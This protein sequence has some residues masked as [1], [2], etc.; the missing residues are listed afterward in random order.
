MT[1]GKASDADLGVTARIMSRMIGSSPPSKSSPAAVCR[2][3]LKPQAKP[4]N[5]VRAAYEQA[6]SPEGLSVPTHPSGANCSEI[7][8]A[9]GVTKTLKCIPSACGQEK[10][11]MLTG[12]PSFLNSRVKLS[13]NCRS[14]PT[15]ISWGTTQPSSPPGGG[16]EPHPRRG[17]CGRGRQRLRLPPQNKERTRR[18]RSWGTWFF[19]TDI[20]TTPHAP[21]LLTRRGVFF[22]AADGPPAPGPRPPR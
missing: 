10:A 1:G 17:L 12:S 2:C 11:A 3:L 14:S 20:E 13:P 18:N 5:C 4:Q 8:M 22:A 7:T 9:A 15:W 21:R 6:Q 19:E 16:A